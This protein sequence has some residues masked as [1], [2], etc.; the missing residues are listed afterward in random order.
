LFTNFFAHTA[1]AAKTPGVLPHVTY[2]K[3]F[4]LALPVFSK[5]AFRQA[6]MLGVWISATLI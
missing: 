6:H 3:R 2:P 4:I 1:L 5:L